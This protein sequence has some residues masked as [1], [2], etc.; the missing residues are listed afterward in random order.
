MK[1][2]HQFVK[3]IEL[4]SSV[5]SHIRQNSNLENASVN[6]STPVTSFHLKEADSSPTNYIKSY[7][8]INNLTYL[9]NNNSKK[10]NKNND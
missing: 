1:I 4:N 5:S 8:N 7:S 6:Q 2:M 3:K 10:C 9:T